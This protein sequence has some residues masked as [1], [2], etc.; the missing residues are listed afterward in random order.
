MSLIFDDDQGILTDPKDPEWFMPILISVNLVIDN[1][2]RHRI[3]YLLDEDS[4]DIVRYTWKGDFWSEKL[5]IVRSCKRNDDMKHQKNAMLGGALLMNAESIKFGLGHIGV[6][7]AC[8]KE[9]NALLE[10]V[11]LMPALNF[12]SIHSQGH[13]L[14]LSECEQVRKSNDHQDQDEHSDDDCVHTRYLSRAESIF[15][16]VK[17]P[18]WAEK[19]EPNESDAVIADI[20]RLCLS[21]RDTDGNRRDLLTG[22][23]SKASSITQRLAMT[24]KDQR[25]MWSRN[26]RVAW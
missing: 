11:S 26:G 16:E 2:E 20:M 24:L 7:L 12:N 22:A 3:I 17:V 13:Y 9:S 1:V 25:A 21:A 14:R 19:T 4:Q 10:K 8:S 5:I 18:S 15:A 6:H 23:R